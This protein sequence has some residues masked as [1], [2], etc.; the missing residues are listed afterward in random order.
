MLTM[1]S[2]E[3]DPNTKLNSDPCPSATSTSFQGL[4][5]ASHRSSRHTSMSSFPWR[6]APQRALRMLRSTMR[7]AG[8][9]SPWGLALRACSAQSGLMTCVATIVLFRHLIAPPHSTGPPPSRR[10]S[11]LPLAS[12]KR[13]PCRRRRSSLWFLVCLVVGTCWQKGIRMSWQPWPPTAVEAPLRL[14]FLGRSKSACRSE[15]PN[16]DSSEGGR[17]RGGHCTSTTSTR[18]ACTIASAH[19]MGRM[20]WSWSISTSCHGMKATA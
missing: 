19:C 7:G 13:V 16:C 4:Y 11:M 15:L 9:T 8:R 14:E 10:K 20:M 3:A 5:T 1:R 6:L 17:S 2:G 18:S 12:L